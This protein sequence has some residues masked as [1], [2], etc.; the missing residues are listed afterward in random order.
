M[1]L[2]ST[3]ASEIEPVYDPRGSAADVAAADVAVTVNVALSPLV[4]VAGKEG[5]TASQPVPFTVVTVGVTVTAPLQFPITP[6]G[7]V[8]AARGLYPGSAALISVGAAGRDCA[9]TP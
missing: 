2:S 9:S 3:A 8:C 7:K 4:S 5:D 1:P 6:T